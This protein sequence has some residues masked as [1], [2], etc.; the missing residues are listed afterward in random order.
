[1]GE[2]V[3]AAAADSALADY[4]SLTGPGATVAVYRDGQPLLIRSYGASSIEHQ[5]ANATDTVF[6]IASTS[7]QFVACAIAL[8]EA[9]GLVDL[10]APVTGYLPEL[11][12]F[13]PPV[14]VSH[15]VHHSS[16]VRDKYA[17][18]AIGRLPEEMIGT[19]RGSLR[20]LARQR[21]LNFPPGSA[22]MYSNSGYFLLAQIVERVSGRRFADFAEE[23]IFAPL[24]MHHS[25]F[26]H[27]T[28]IVIPHR[29]SGYQRG[30]DGQWHLAEYTWNSLGPGG[31]VTTVTDLARWSLALMTD[32]LPAAK[33]AMRMLDTEPLTDGSANPYAFGLMRD[34][35]QGGL[36]VSHGGGV[37]GFSAEMIH[38]PDERLTVICL[39]NSSAVAAGTCAKRLLDALLPPVPTVPTAVPEARQAPY[40]GQF[41]ATDDTAVARISNDEN[42]WTL[43]LGPMTIPLTQ[44]DGTLQ[45]AAGT[46]LEFG[47]DELVIATGSAAVAPLRFT[48]IQSS[49]ATS[50]PDPAAYCGRYYSDELDVTVT[51]RMTGSQITASWPDGTT[52]ALRLVGPHLLLAD[53]GPGGEQP[54]RLD[55]DDEGNATALRI[56]VA[57]AIGTR[58]IR[59]G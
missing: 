52:A 53:A 14:R 9:D 44:T 43:Q 38:V 20:L 35:R 57:R 6:Y 56:S 24:G 5:V 16:G 31:L 51:C 28:T 29:A 8:L 10:A 2:P 7:K 55:F 40:P 46:A 33:V 37:S 39:A 25:R 47:P 54:I 21:S 13:D 3:L 32:G 23:R 34:Q 15:L 18:A 45:T 1:M 26:R 41:L 27:D 17:L 30:A 42:G 48:R 19:D 49:A 58:F 36:V 12:A 50:E 4:T 59:A 11:H 22:F